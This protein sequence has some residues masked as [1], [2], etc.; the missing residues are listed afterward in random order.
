MGVFGP[1]KRRWRDQEG[2]PAFPREQPAE[3]SQE[4]AVDGS[5]PDATVKLALQHPDLVAEDHEFDVFVSVGPAAR[6]YERQDPAQPEVQERE[7]HG[8]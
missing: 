2:S 1:Y 8:P 3:R 5:V 6:D 7:S 4:G